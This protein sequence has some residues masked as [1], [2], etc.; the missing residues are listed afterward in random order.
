MAEAVTAALLLVS[1][2]V[3]L[4]IILEEFVRK[5][6]CFGGKCIELLLKLPPP[7]SFTVT[8]VRFTVTA[9]R[10]TVTAVRFTVTAVR[11]TVTSALPLVSCVVAL[12]II[13]KD[14]VRKLWCFGGKC[15]E[16]LKLSPPV[17]FTAVL[18]VPREE[19]RGSPE[20]IAESYQPQPQPVALPLSSSIRSGGY[21]PLAEPEA[22]P[23]SS[24]SEGW[25]MPSPGGMHI[26]MVKPQKRRNVVQTSSPVTG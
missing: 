8:A 19:S 24:D 20:P 14:F 16:L 5:L 3:A 2:V 13:L 21:F 26:R 6:W 4:A 23:D 25:A 7:V 17:C 12:A 18:Q 11:F 22:E 9:V 1:C 10:F 15:I